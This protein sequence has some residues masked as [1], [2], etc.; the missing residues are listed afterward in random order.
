MEQ[1]FADDINAII[2][3]SREVAIRY[4]QYQIDLDHLMLALTQVEESSARKLLVDLGCDIKALAHL[5]EKT[6]TPFKERKDGNIPLTRL[7]ESVLK[8]TF[9]RP[10]T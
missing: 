10:M 4:E 6:F 3:Q 8:G 7:A 2:R 5:I 1:P 9:M